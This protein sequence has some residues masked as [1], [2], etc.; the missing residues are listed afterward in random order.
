MKK[1]MI[2]CIK[3]NDLS[4]FN[5]YKTPVKALGESIFKTRDGKSVHNRVLGEIGDN[6]SFSDTSN[7]LNCF[8]FTKEIQKIKERQEFFKKIPRNINNNTLKELKN[9]KQTWKPKYGIVAVTD[10]EDTFVKLKNLDIPVKFLVNE[11]D[12]LDLQNYEIVQVVDVEQFSSLIEQ[13][14]QSVFLESI[15][16][17][18][19]ERYLELLSGWADNFKVLENLEDEEIK[20]IVYEIKPLLELIGVSSREKISRSHIENSLE[21][22]NQEISNKIKDLNVS[23]QTLFSMLSEGK[24]PKEIEKIVEEVIKNKNIPENI[25][26]FGIPVKINEQEIE[27]FIRLQDANE[28][29]GFSEKIK[30]NSKALKQIPEKLGRLSALLLIYDFIAGISIFIKDNEYW[31]EFSEEFRIENVKN[32]FLEKA[33]AISFNLNQNEKCSILTGANSGGK[34]TL[35]E[36]IIQIISLT[37]FGFPING[38]VS[39]PVFSEV[40]YFAKNKG[41]ASKGAFE[42]LLSQMSE[43]KPGK[44][45]LILADEIEAVTEPGVAGKI[46]AATSEYFIGKNCFLIIATHLGY[47]IKKVLPKN[48][49]IDG[50]EAKGLDENNELIVDHNP[51]LGRLANSTPELIVEKMARSGEHD[52]F[53][54]LHEYLKNNGNGQNNL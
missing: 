49:R 12:V 45:T 34:T 3:E 51:V 26:E 30:R 8:P 52:Y 43:I 6:F 7:L 33:Q 25:F 40:Y 28:N 16:D 10:N 27:N 5:L 1:E 36:H 32:I 20:K 11:D 29:T 42:T 9:P 22:I 44:N 47:E 4:P 13:L 19:L 17:V 46:I 15:D 14:P 37:N 31:P 18:Y 41:S 38:Q 35:I 48:S 24:M 21:E 39:I 2:E 23:G 50:I 54:Y 53:S